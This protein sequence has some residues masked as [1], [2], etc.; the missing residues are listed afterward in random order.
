MVCVRNRGLGRARLYFYDTDDRR[1]GAP[2]LLGPH[3]HSSK[4]TQT[5][6]ARSSVRT[7]I[8][9]QRHCSLSHT[10]ITLYHSHRQPQSVTAVVVQSSSPYL[11]LSSGRLRSCCRFSSLP[12]GQTC[13]QISS[14]LAPFW[15]HS[16]VV[17]YEGGRHGISLLRREKRR[18]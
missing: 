3:F 17:T 11:P 1:S 5:I 15:I 6:A 2:A 7:R 8:V 14:L 9:Q 16:L 13:M 18:L 4:Q 10:R 12:R